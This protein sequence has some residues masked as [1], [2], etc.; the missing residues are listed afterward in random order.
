[1]IDNI[2]NILPF[3]ISESFNIIKGEELYFY[4]TSKDSYKFP[5][6]FDSKTMKF[7]FFD[8]SKEIITV[9][10]EYSPI[11]CQAHNHHSLECPISANELPQDVRF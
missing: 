9:Y 10:F 8:I 3:N 11:T 5:S 1:M 7:I 2:I 4:T 6:I